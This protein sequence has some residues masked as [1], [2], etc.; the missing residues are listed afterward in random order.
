MR[1]Y[2]LTY[3]HK[4]IIIYFRIL[5]LINIAAITTYT[6]YN[7]NVII[8]IEINPRSRTIDD[9]YFSIKF[10][11]GTNINFSTSVSIITKTSLS[12]N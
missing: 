3:W 5:F 1:K 10:S 4:S 11:T 2:V 8:H 9:T 7:L 12:T 6:N